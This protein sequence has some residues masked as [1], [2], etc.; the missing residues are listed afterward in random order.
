M[1]TLFFKDCKTLSDV[2]Q[3]YRDLVKI[4]HPDKGGD[5]LTMKSINN[6]YEKAV[7][8]IVAG[9]TLTAEEQEAEILNAEAYKNALNALQN[10]LGLVI[11][12][13]GGWLWVSGN[14]YAHRAA[15]AAF[16]A[17]NPNNRFFWASKKKMWYFRAPEYATKGK[18]KSLDMEQI[19]GKY[20]SQLISGTRP[21]YQIAS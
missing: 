8:H 18:H 17:E 5:E 4:H 13:C 2:K 15:F 1:T 3:T 14:T 7:K 10:L 9:G 19:R 12:V 21:A 16:N 11:E 6:E 20:G